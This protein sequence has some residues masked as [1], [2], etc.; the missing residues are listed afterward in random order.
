[1]NSATQT[2]EMHTGISSGGAQNIS[3]SLENIWKVWS[4]VITPP[5][6][7]SQCSCQT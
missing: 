7:L 3:Q 6:W 2:L 5:D 4:S 1:V